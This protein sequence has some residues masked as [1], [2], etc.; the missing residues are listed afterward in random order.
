MPAGVDVARLAR[1]APDP[2][3]METLGRFAGDPL[4][5]FVG[6]ALPHKRIEVLIHAQLLLDQLEVQSTLAIVGVRTDPVL[7]RAL[8]E[9]AHDLAIPRVHLLGGLGDDALAAV[10]RNADIAVTASEHEGLCLPVLEAMAMGVPVIARGAGA[11][12]ETI[13]DAGLVLDRRAGPADFAEAVRMLHHDPLL[14]GELGY[15]GRRRAADFALERNLTD[16]L[17]V[18]CE[19]V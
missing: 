12:P 5:V 15:R 6:Q 19:V 3:A 7:S 10:L 13:A 17:D 8:A 4:L 2:S 14:A 11:L 9:V 18:L 16:F 1:E